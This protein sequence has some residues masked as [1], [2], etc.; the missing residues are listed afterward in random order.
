MG[1]T[2]A[3]RAMN[4]IQKDLGVFSLNLLISFEFL[5]ISSG[6][7]KSYGALLDVPTRVEPEAGATIQVSN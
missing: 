1:L 2:D 3:N 7:A 4:V 6:Y 5:I